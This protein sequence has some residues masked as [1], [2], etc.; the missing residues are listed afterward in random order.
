[1]KAYILSI[2]AT[3]LWVLLLVS[4]ALVA[5]SA[6]RSSAADRLAGGAAVQD[7]VKMA[8]DGD[9]LTGLYG[10]AQSNVDPARGG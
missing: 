8:V 9:I 4:S 10:A 5:V 1:M 7:G 2:V 6:A 3:R